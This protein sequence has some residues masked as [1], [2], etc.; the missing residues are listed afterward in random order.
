MP[1]ITQSWIDSLDRHTFEKVAALHLYHQRAMLLWIDTDACAEAIFAEKNQSKSN[2][3]YTEFFFP[4]YSMWASMVYVVDEGFVALD[5]QDAQLQKA[6]QAIDMKLF[7]RFRNATFHYQ[8]H[9]RSPKHGEL[10]MTKGFNAARILFDRQ[11]VLL[12]RIGRLM[13]KM[14]KRDWVFSDTSVYTLE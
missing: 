12:R 1:E 10:I 2:E 6:R 8:P 3:I 4:F 14:P 5:I 9:F 13:R 7:K 11:G